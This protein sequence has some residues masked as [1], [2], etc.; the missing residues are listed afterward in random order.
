VKFGGKSLK[1]K[2]INAMLMIP[3]LNNEIVLVLACPYKMMMV[4]L[5][6]L[7]DVALTFM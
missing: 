4:D 1:P 7:N 2:D 5:Y 6:P 3:S